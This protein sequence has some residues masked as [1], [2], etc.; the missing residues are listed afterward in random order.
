MSNKND[1][2]AAFPIHPGANIDR[3]RNGM[4]LRD[5]FAAQIAAG[6]AAAGEGWGDTDRLQ[7]SMLLKRARLYYRLADA[8]IAVRAESGGPTGD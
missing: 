4:T 7:E 3:E 5:H 6:D 8:M 1:G 2:G